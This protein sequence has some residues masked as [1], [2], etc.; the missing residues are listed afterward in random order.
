MA[1]LALPAY[2]ASRLPPNASEVLQLLLDLLVTLCLDISRV[3]SRPLV[4]FGRVSRA[5]GASDVSTLLAGG[6]CG[7]NE[8][9]LALVAG[10][11]NTLRCRLV[12]SLI[13]RPG[14][15]GQDFLLLGLLSSLLFPLALFTG[16][17]LLRVS[18]ALLAALVLALMAHLLY[19]IACSTS[20]AASVDTHADGL[21]NTRDQGSCRGCSN[22]FV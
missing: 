22:P 12:F 7:W 13:A 14:V 8:Q 20:V 18:G 17:L 15:E 16:C 6:G 4:A 19:A 5:L 2:Y 21:L 9:G 10:A 11:P 3:P 1:L